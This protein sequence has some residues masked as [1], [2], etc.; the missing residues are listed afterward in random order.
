MQRYIP[1]AKKIRKINGISTK[2]LPVILGS[3]AKDIWGTT[4]ISLNKNPQY[5]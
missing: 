5:P 4:D 1:L 3:F 2:I